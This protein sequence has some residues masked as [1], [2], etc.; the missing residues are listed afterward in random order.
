[1]A[2]KQG[3][4]VKLPLSYDSED[5]PYRLTKTLQE[6][7]QQNFKNL[8]LTNPGERVMIPTFGAGIRQ[9]LFEPITEELFSRVRSRIFNQV[10]IYMP[11][12]N[13]EDVVFN[14]LRNK[15]D[16]GPNEVQVS[17]VYNILPLDARDTLT[18]SNSAS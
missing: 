14:T 9:L 12:V 17:I 4:G 7:V 8:M 1:M 5:G 15:Q 11:F 16:L 3:I 13:V 10:R 6:N 2:S 18:I